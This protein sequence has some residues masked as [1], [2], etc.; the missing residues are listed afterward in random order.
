MF[1]KSNSK[2]FIKLSNRTL[3]SSQFT[4]LTSPKNTEPHRVFI[5]S[6]HISEVQ[7][8]VKCTLTSLFAGTH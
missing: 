7:M 8:L 5:V 4:T 3:Q 2:S 1:D 6:I